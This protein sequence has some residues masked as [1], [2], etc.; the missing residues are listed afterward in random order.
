[1]STVAIE[2]PALS[3]EPGGHKRTSLRFQSGSETCHAWLYKPAASGKERSLPIVV[4][5]HGLGGVKQMLLHE[6]AKRFQEAGYACLVFD[7]R[8]LG[9][10]SGEPRGLVNVNE[11]LEDFRAAVAFARSLPGIDAERV[12][13]W[14]TSFA[15]GHVIVTAA[16]D[17]RIAAVIS[18]CPF[19]DGPA[20][21]SVI[22]LST[23][24]RLTLK[25]T[26]DV[27]A[28]LLGRKP[29][30]VPLVGKPGEVAILTTPDAA[31]GFDALLKASGVR[32]VVDL[33]ARIVFQ[34]LRYQP[35]KW[36]K[37][38]QCPAFFCICDGDSVAPAST[39]IAY[40]KQAANSEIGHYPEGHFEIYVGK[41][42][43]RIVADQIAFLAKHVP[44]S[45]N[46]H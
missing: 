7:Y 14:G 16:Q 46:G 34:L 23:K 41:P 29:V 27:L 43:E 21:G 35:G 25:A 42:M 45:S 38:V 37:A 44:A 31:P 1:M 30:R 9:E 20:T 40:A 13:L 32:S 4:M 15:G 3:T 39:T 17:A 28:R 18:Q 36:A 6:Y 12:I 24:I 26:M 19:T 2:R 11:Q 22:D 5:A 33:P 10:S 8:Y